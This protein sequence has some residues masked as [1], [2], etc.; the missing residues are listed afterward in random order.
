M[1]TTC[2]CHDFMPTIR[3]EVKWLFFYFL[4]GLYFFSLVWILA[5]KILN[6]ME[7]VIPRKVESEY[8][9]SKREPKALDL[10]LNQA[11]DY[12]GKKNNI[13]VEL[14][15]HRGWLWIA[16][17]KT[18]DLSPPKS[19]TWNVVVFYLPWYY[20][21]IPISYFYFVSIFKA[22]HP[23]N[24]PSVLVSFFFWR[25]QWLLHIFIATDFT[26]PLGSPKPWKEVVCLQA[27]VTTK[28]GFVIFF[29]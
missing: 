28:L 19:I 11:E 3:L 2:V 24:A 9:L 21:F 14:I 20:V 5:V 15:L 16:C 18:L 4:L 7:A 1:M 10:R 29:V 12:V 22:I 17:N 26:H 6:D 23:L 13:F 8:E 25:P 27:L